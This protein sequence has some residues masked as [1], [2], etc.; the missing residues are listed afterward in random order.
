ML[1]AG[2]LARLACPA[3]RLGRFFFT[4]L[5]LARERCGPPAG[6]DSSSG[7]THVPRTTFVTDGA[8]IHASSCAFWG[9]T[10]C[11]AASQ[12]MGERGKERGKRRGGQ[13]KRYLERIGGDTQSRS[14]VAAVKRHVYI[15]SPPLPLP[16]PARL[17]QS[18]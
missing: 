1:A 3:H 6:R 16:W 11:P 18:A 2:N 8:R 4:R 12:P 15:A 10:R 7:L 17:V 14:H 9:V 13:A 5:A